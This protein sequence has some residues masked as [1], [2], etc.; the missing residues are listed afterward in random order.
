MSTVRRTLCLIGLAYVLALPSVSHA[1]A[2]QA[3]AAPFDPSSDC[4]GD[5]ACMEA[6]RA[7]DMNAPPP[8]ALIMV[9]PRYP[10]AAI[11]NGRTGR[12]IVCFDVDESGAVRRPVILA[13]SGEEF[14]APV[15]AALEQSMFAPAI[16][17]RKAVKSR[18]CRTYRFLLD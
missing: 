8:R 2:A 18:A 11:D 10:V 1:L 6:A 4:S 12:V 14:E 9:I 15:L 7:L 17:G 16:S 13:S 5:Q 3:D